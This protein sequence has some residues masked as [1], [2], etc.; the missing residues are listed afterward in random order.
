MLFIGDGRSFRN[1]VVDEVL[2]G[3]VQIERGGLTADSYGVEALRDD[4]ALVAVS[5]VR[6]PSE[7]GCYCTHDEV[8]RLKVWK[9]NLNA[10]SRAKVASKWVRRVRNSTGSRFDTKL[11]I[12]SIAWK[13]TM[14]AVYGKIASGIQ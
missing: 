11:Y 9:T 8:V 3:V 7:E 10:E 1:G 13:C 6:L 12:P 5:V 4:A 14:G 2:S